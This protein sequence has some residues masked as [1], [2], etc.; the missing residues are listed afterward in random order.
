MRK[1][2]LLQ[3]CKRKNETYERVSIEVRDWNIKNEV[4]SQNMI[5]VDDNLWKAEVLLPLTSLVENVDYSFKVDKHSYT[6]WGFKKS[7]N[8]I[9]SDVYQMQEEDTIRQF[10]DKQR[11]L[12]SEVVV[13]LKDIVTRHSKE[14]TL[15]DCTMQIE[16]FC[17]RNHFS[18]EDH[19]YLYRNLLYAIDKESKTQLLL[20]AV[21]FG[22]LFKSDYT[23]A[24]N[25]LSSE[26]AHKVCSSFTS[27]K[28]IELSSSCSNYL[29]D[30]A[31]NFCRVALGRHYSFLSCISIVYPFFDE[32]FISSKVNEVVRRKKCLVAESVQDVTEKH[33]L[34]LFEK[35][36]QRAEMEQA[37]KLLEQLILHIPLSQALTI[38]IDL[39]KK[40]S[41]L[42]ISADGENM[43][44]DT[45]L[46]KARTFLRS[47]KRNMKELESFVL[48]IDRIPELAAA[49]AELE[50]SI[51]RNVGTA[52]QNEKDSLTE[53]ILREDLFV[54]EKSQLHL[55][56]S[57]TSLKLPYLHFIL[58]DILMEKKFS[59]ALPKADTVW[60]HDCFYNA[61]LHI[62]R[63]EN[64]D[65]RLEYVYKY[66]AKAQGIFVHLG[67][68]ELISYLNKTGLE[69]L[70]AIDLRK[71]MKMTQVIEDLSEK[72]SSIG[73]M[74][75]RHVQA[76]LRDQYESNYHE[77]LLSLCG[78][79]GK[80]RINS[81]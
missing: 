49:K 78:T 81:R 23:V 1:E 65:K 4:H 80:L 64:E 51:S 39:K 76:I 18:I 38:Y 30:V 10:F 40:D 13:H 34:T 29:F 26:M 79:Y 57:F 68:E 17:K 62:K 59:E 44:R 75:N 42:F 20:C 77:M 15:A 14:K 19:K 46:E 7:S 69:Y 22:N 54:T 72:D 47:T 70:K 32:T 11:P 61:V 31:D 63:E 33:I 71:L 12:R 50:T 16:K 36:C 58:F 74:F 53:L 66:L 48:S 55:I 3:L 27:F 5:A 25:F 41:D 2:I 56:K 73:D 67:S 45:L 9:E 8:T 21:V 37:R 43:L 52:M 60:F 6:Y 24:D 35:V 28:S